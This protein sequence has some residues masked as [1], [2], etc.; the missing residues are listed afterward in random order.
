MKKE[1]VK[2]IKKVSRKKIPLSSLKGKV[3]PSRKRKLIEEALKK[4][5]CEESDA[6][7]EGKDRI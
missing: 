4:E 5:R 1:T 6:G 7:S 2:S 3:M